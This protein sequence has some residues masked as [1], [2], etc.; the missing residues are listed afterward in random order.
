[1]AIR[2]PKEEKAEYVRRLQE[3]VQ[4]EFDL[5]IGE[6]ATEFLLDFVAEL[7]GPAY[8]NEALED[9]RAVAS[10]RADSIQEEILALRKEPPR[11]R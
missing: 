8:Y 10:N 2:L 11:R 1:M 9:A 3:Y 4:A 7:A 6:L 5:E